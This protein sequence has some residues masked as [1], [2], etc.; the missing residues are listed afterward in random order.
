MALEGERLWRERHGSLTIAIGIEGND[1]YHLAGDSWVTL[2]GGLRLDDSSK[3]RVRFL[4]SA[5]RGEIHRLKATNRD[6]AA[7]EAKQWVNF[8]RKIKK[9]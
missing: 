6:D 8:V 1:L 2:P 9:L 3:R 5:V 4:V 7:K